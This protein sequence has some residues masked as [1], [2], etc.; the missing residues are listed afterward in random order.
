MCD[1]RSKWDD[2]DVN[3]MV[4]K[5][6]NLFHSDKLFHAHRLVDALERSLLACS[7][8]DPGNIA[9]AEDARD[10]LEGRP[11]VDE[12]KRRVKHTVSLVSSMLS[13]NDEWMVVTENANTRSLY[14]DQVGETLHA[15]KLEGYIKAPM[16]AVVACINE[17][18]LYGEWMPFNI[19]GKTLTQISPWAKTVH[20]NIAV[21]GRV[22]A[23]RDFALL[24]FAVDALEHDAAF[25]SS[26]SWKSHPIYGEAPKK[27]GYWSV[28]GEIWDTGF[29]IV[30]VSPVQTYL[31]IHCV[32]DIKMKLIP[33]SVMNWGM[34]K[35]VPTFFRRIRR[36]SEQIFSGN[37]AGKMK[38]SVYHD[39][40]RASASVGTYT[41][42][43][44][45]LGSYFRG[46]IGSY[47]GPA[48]SND[49]FYSWLESLANG[50]GALAD[51]P[52]SPFVKKGKKG[53]TPKP[54]AVDTTPVVS[55]G[56][57][58]ATVA[59]PPTPGLHVSD[60][61]VEELEGGT[62]PDA[63]E[64][65]AEVVVDLVEAVFARIDGT[66]PVS[67]RPVMTPIAGT[68][69]GDEKLEG[70]DDE[71]EDDGFELI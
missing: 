38:A 36:K 44:K 54:A 17:V 13:T 57:T 30:P 1:L 45:R 51:A 35:A 22:V 48:P 9:A 8:E 58:G 68:V 50:Q 65:A 41:T 49:A 61:T 20:A 5:I 63:I 59:P 62:S 28:R 71:D 14:K 42:L 29:Y 52:P 2:L 25:I 18:E 33:P 39:A 64:A 32:A 53:G 43:M 10:L 7:E 55:P 37:A 70:E 27:S 6:L 56:A 16:M 66:E 24:G 19:K 23:N 3:G 47:G 26:D 60:R 40:I 46:E 15:F 69:G 21:P 12:V 11:E 34:T 31:V 4:T 67:I